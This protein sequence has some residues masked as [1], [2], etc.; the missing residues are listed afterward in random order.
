MLH[1]FSARPDLLRIFPPSL[2]AHPH[3]TVEVFLILLGLSFTFSATSVLF[4][5]SEF[6]QVPHPHGFTHSFSRNPGVYPSSGRGIPATGLSI[7]RFGD[8]PASGIHRQGQQCEGRDRSTAGLMLARP[9]KITPR[10]ARIL[11]I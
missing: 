4:G 5:L 7:L 9:A 6:Q 1:A 2:T 11:Y 10:A 3:N 8:L